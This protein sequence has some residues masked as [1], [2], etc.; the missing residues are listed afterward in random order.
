MDY[1]PKK[2]SVFEVWVKSL[3]AYVQAHLTAFNIQDAVFQPLLD[4]NM[5]WETAYAKTLDPNKGAVDVA[6]KNRAR[7]TLEKA[8]RSFVKAFLLYSPFVSDTDRD[9]MQLPIH[10][11]KPTPVPPPATYPEYSLDTSVPSRLFVH[12]WDEASKQRGKPRGVHGAEVRWELRDE[13]P[14]KAEDL[15]NSDFATR[16]PHTLVFTGDKQG[17]RVYF[18]L[19]WENNKGEKG[20]WGAVMSAV[21]P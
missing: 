7:D 20:P 10:D 15:S 18:C 14:A 12:F 17:Q 2:D 3:L 11:T 4:L 8:L 1:V 6:D 13:A 21:V 19:R 16:T 9:E 5:A